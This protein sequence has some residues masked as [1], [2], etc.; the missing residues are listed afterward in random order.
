MG[1]GTLHHV[2]QIVK[3]VAQVFLL[4]PSAVTSPVVRVGGVLSAG[5]V[6][7]A[8]GLLGAAD[9]IN[10]GIDISPQLLVGIGLKDVAGTLDGFVG[11]G[12]VEGVAYA[13]HLEHLRGVF[14]VLPGIVE[15]LVAAFA[16]AL[17]EG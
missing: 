16:L 11:V 6:E 17:R 1:Y 8:I 13:V 12:V 7:V 9:D 5:G 2:A 15:V 3:L 14:Q 4:Y 10:Y